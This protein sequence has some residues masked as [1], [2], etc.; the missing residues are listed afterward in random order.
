[1]W[2]RLVKKY[3]PCTSPKL[4]KLKKE[5]INI[6]LNDINKDPNEWITEL[7]SL[8]VQKNQIHLVSKMSDQDLMIHIM[9]SLLEQYNPVIDNLEKKTLT[10]SP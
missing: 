6:K 4:L 5:F 9:N 10:T 2:E 1:M 3:E 7:E 8:W